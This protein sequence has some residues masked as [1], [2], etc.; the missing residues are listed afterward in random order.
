MSIVKEIMATIT[1]G[2]CTEKIRHF[3]KRFI[4]PIE[5]PAVCTEIF[6]MT[7]CSREHAREKGER[8]APEIIV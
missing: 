5:P 7:S 4:K 6:R 8:E 2:F 3:E 1:N